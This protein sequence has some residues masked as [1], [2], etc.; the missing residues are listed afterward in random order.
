MTLWIG[1]L[2][3]LF[4]ALQTALEAGLI[5]L[6]LRRSVRA[7]GAGGQA[8]PPAL[9][10][11]AAPEAVARSRAY[12]QARLRL[13]LAAQAIEVVLLP[14][15]LFSGLLPA[16]DGR[17][18]AWGLNGPHRFAAFLAGLAALF[19]L[20]GLPFSLYRT[21]R[22]EVRF[23]F[24]RATPA[25]W[26]AD[27]AKGLAL[28]A[29]LGLPF[30]YG[31]FAFMARTGQAWWLGLF[32]F[33]A[34]AQAALLWLYPTVIAPW[35]NRFTPLA[36][37]TLRE[38]LEALAARA[39]FSLRG[40][41]V[42]DAS[43]R[44]GHSNAYFTGLLRP[45]IV[46][47]DT[48]VQSMSEDETLAVLAHE[49][50]HYRARHMHRMLALNLAGMLLGLYLLSLLIAWPPVFHRFGF[51]EPSLHAGLALALLCG[52]AF[53]FWLQPAAAWLSRRHEYEADRYS[54]RLLAL[55]DALKRALV[56]LSGENLANPDP[57]PWY[58]AYH[59]S[60]PTLPERLAAI[61]RAAI[62]PGT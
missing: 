34:A 49:M 62:Q 48:L 16:W 33:I 18:A 36:A 53:T 26:L 31:A 39:G 32:G 12:V 7:G 38:R 59:Y 22:I 58:S 4:F 37:G 9:R 35:F 2:Y 13:D 24:N 5:L 14:A 23:G 57:H 56:R 30:L 40:I 27:R 19:F 6:N 43:R 61:D 47:F 21:F 54:V 29:G 60:H 55:P 1:S 17:L 44:S 20:A 11:L 10:G 25:L 51:A 3:I 8:V 46:L 50:G 15:L 42:V 41:F 28:A 52:G 45:R